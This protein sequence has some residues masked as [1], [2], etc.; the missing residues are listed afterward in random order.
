MPPNT[1][2]LCYVLHQVDD[3][4]TFKNGIY[5]FMLYMGV[6]VGTGMP[7]TYMKVRGHPVAGRFSSYHVDLGDG[8]QVIS[9]NSKSLCPLSYLP[10]PSTHSKSS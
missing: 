3:T 2:I 5:L 4:H 7:H 9:L 1:L 6:G 10:S 8:T